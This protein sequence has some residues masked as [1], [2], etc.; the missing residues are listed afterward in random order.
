MSLL[1]VRQQRHARSGMAIEAI[2]PRLGSYQRNSMRRMHAH[3]PR[4]NISRS[5]SSKSEGF[6]YPTSPRPA[7]SRFSDKQGE[8]KRSRDIS[9]FELTLLKSKVSHGNARPVRGNPF[10]FHQIEKPAGSAAAVVQDANAVTKK[11][12]TKKKALSGHQ[13]FGDMFQSSK[14]ASITYGTN[15]RSSLQVERV[16]AFPSTATPFPSFA[17]PGYFRLPQTVKPELP[18][19]IITTTNENK[20]RGEWGLKQSLPTDIRPSHVIVTRLDNHKLGSRGVYRT[21]TRELGDMERWR[22]LFGYNENVPQRQQE[23]F[24]LVNGLDAWEKQRAARLEKEALDKERKATGAQLNKP[25]FGEKKSLPIIKRVKIN[26]DLLDTNTYLAL[27]KRARALSREWIDASSSASA[28]LR[29]DEWER[30]LNIDT[31]SDPSNGISSGSVDFLLSHSYRPVHPPFYLV[32]P[33]SRAALA[34]SSERLS[35]IAPS[36]NTTQKD[37]P[38]NALAS[39]VLGDSPKNSVVVGRNNNPAFR[40]D[41]ISD[42]FWN[43]PT[44]APFPKP[45][46]PPLPLL[47]SRVMVRYLNPLTGGRAGHAVSVNGFVAFVPHQFEGGLADMANRSQTFQEKREF[48]ATVKLAEVGPDGTPTIT[49]SL[50]DSDE[51][52]ARRGANVFGGRGRQEGLVSNVVAAGKR[53]A[54]NKERGAELMEKALQGGTGLKSRMIEGEMGAA[55]EGRKVVSGLDFDLGGPAI[56]RRV[57][58]DYRRQKQERQLM[59]L[60]ESKEAKESGDKRNRDVAE[61]LS[62]V[63]KP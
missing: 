32:S 43:I 2:I 15:A 36:G 49:V 30:F 25:L 37:S 53:A 56:S 40:N 29:M 59:G 20:A 9:S 55:V 42:E 58:G 17:L 11:V 5:L 7:S 23:A 41:N 18:P 60:V 52:V 1:R 21:A 27:L 8:T 10:P 28:A 62:K 31:R 13:S 46:Q 16:G 19:H 35:N 61:I 14:L 6:Q 24:R 57:G 4:L 3:R 45:P 47:K 38:F 12:E 44:I 54:L 48:P 26:P 39:V 22:L 51:F 50:R 63:M 34:E 33:I